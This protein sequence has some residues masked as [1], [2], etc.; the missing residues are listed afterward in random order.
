M[1]SGPGRGSD[2]CIVSAGLGALVTARSRMAIHPPITIMKKRRGRPLVDLLI[3]ISKRG[4]AMLCLVPDQRLAQERV[5]IMK[6]GATGSHHRD[7]IGKDGA[8]NRA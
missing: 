3:G 7:E 1:S 6:D 4:E 2:A 5:Q 8:G